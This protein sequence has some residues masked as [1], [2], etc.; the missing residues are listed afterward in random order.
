MASDA[1]AR[2]VEVVRALLD[3]IY[4]AS[5]HQHTSDLLSAMEKAL[6]D[7]HRNKEAFIEFEAR[8]PAHFNILKYHMM[9]HYVEPIKLFRTADRF[10]TEWSERLHIDY[11]KEAYRASNKKDYMIQMTTWLRHQKSVDRFTMYL[12]WCRNSCPGTSQSEEG[13]VK[14]GTGDYFLI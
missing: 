11:A 1:P 12:Y 2:V 3:F 9:E 8:H 14:P 13:R 7:L 4:L 6:D 5:L 10:N